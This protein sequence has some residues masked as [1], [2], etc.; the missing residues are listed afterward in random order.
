MPLDRTAIHAALPQKGFEM[1]DSDSDHTVFVYHSSQN[2]KT[3]LRTKTSRGTSHKV[4]SDPLIGQ[5]CRQC[6]VTA[7]QF[8][9]LVSCTL[10]R[11]DYEQILIANNHLTLETSPPPEKP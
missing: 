7:A 5:M 1:D 2:K 6:G 8:K 4:I 11:D 10:S 9:N 3:K